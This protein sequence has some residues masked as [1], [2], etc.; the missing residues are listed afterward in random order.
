M[1][2][3]F[4]NEIRSFFNSLIAYIVIIIFLTGIG[5]YMWVF[6]ETIVDIGLAQ[7][8][9]LFDAGPYVFMFLIPAITMRTFAEEKKGGTLELLLTRPLREWELVLGKYLAAFVLTIIA[10]IPT[11]VYYYSIYQLAEPVGNV[12]S[13]AIIGSYVGLLFLAMTYTALGI[14]ASSFTEN[15]IIAFMISLFLSLF[16]FEG[17][18][19]ISS[20]NQW[21][22]FA[23]VLSEMGFRSHFM[24]LSKGVIDTR[25]VIYFISMTGMFLLLAKM[26]LNSRKWSK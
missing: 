21:G 1:G 20:I 16:F 12:D 26:K 22:R 2:S 25:D 14:M 24:S 23:V 7:M 19:Y 9:M 18:Q 4:L 10:L 5:L 17:F 13:G 8:D 3:I 15:Q 11:L 6:P